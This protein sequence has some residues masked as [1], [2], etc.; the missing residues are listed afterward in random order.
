MDLT[1]LSRLD[2]NDLKKIDYRKLLEDLKKKPEIL[3]AIASILLSIFVLAQIVSSS[4]KDRKALQEEKGNLEAK[5]KQIETL[6][7]AKEDLASFLSNIPP[8]LDQSEA[9]SFLTDLANTRSIKIV[10]LFPSTGEST[11]YYDSFR[12]DL[13]ILAENYEN[14]W[15]FIR[16][17]EDYK[18]TIRVESWEAATNTDQS[19]PSRGTPSPAKPE[20]EGTQL[21]VRIQLTAVNLKIQT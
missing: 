6:T 11:D 3:V 15:L 12:I 2:I 7:K 8:V 21:S 1:K 9:V 20:G 4:Q 13:N 17:I 19:S 10:S 16:D 5:I 18:Y 14:L